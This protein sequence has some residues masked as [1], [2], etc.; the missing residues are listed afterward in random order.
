MERDLGPLHNQLDAK[1]TRLTDGLSDGSLANKVQKAEDHA[2]QLNESAGILDGYATG[3]R[4][5]LPYL[6]A[7][8]KSSLVQGG[9]IDWSLQC[10]FFKAGCVLSLYSQNHNYLSFSL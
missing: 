2:R 1:V 10:L 8:D 7:E 4:N 9:N 5:E 6:L 3:L